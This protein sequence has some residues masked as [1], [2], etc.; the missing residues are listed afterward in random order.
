M[1]SIYADKRKT[2]YD[3]PIV[4]D[5][6]LSLVL[7]VGSRSCQVFFLRLKSVEG[8]QTSGYASTLTKILELTAELT[9]VSTAAQ[10]QR[11]QE[12]R[13]PRAWN[14]IASGRDTFKTT[15]FI[16]PFMFFC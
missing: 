15:A 13:P 4:H 10:L 9:T 3:L 16:I 6:F 5:S 2:D 7:Q 12:A 1:I 14:P 8:R 11:G